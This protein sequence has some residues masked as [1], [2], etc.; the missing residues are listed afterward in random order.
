MKPKED[1]IKQIAESLKLSIL[2]IFTKQNPSN[3]RAKRHFT[4]DEL[5]L[6]NAEANNYDLDLDEYIAMRI[7]G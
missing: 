2:D 1:K 4:F 5:I 6:F 7:M 3:L